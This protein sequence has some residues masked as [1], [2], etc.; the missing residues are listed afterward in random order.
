MMYYT[1]LWAI[2]MT[3]LVVNS[4]LMVSCMCVS[5]C[6]ST[7]AVA[8]SMQITLASVSRARARHT[9][10]RWPMEKTR[11]LS[12][13]SDSKPPAEIQNHMQR[14]RGLPIFSNGYIRIHYPISKLVNFDQ[15]LVNGWTKKK[16]ITFILFYG[17][18]CVW[19]SAT[20][21]VDRPN[22]EA[23]MKRV[24]ISTCTYL[25][26]EQQSLSDISPAQTTALGQST[27]IEHDNQHY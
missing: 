25:N 9:S 6:R 23:I 14:G 12:S 11:P 19:V 21:L 5:V 13:T 26:L 4:L 3:V 8:S 10:W 16:T 27:A 22:R 1:Y 2:V 20:M 17:G 7:L 15:D 24:A 18:L